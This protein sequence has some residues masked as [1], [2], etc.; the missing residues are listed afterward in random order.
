MKVNT[1]NL[2]KN[3][4]N[5]VLQLKYRN[6]DSEEGEFVALVYQAMNNCNLDMA[7]TLMKTFSDKDDYGVQEAVVNVL[8][9]IEIEIYYRALLEELPRLVDEAAEWA[10]SLIAG[11]IDA[12]PD[13]L[14]AMAKKL[15]NDIRVCLI[16]L[17]KDTGM[18]EYVSN[19]KDFLVE[20]G[21]QKNDP[22]NEAIAI[23]H[24][25]PKPVLIDVKALREKVDMTEIGFASALGIDLKT[26]RYWERGRLQPRGPALALLKVIAKKPDFV[27]SILSQS[28]IIDN[29]GMSV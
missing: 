13:L 26:L 1:T 18:I 21:H 16:H 25:K 15:S 6:N 28:K 7:K 29:S 19:A 22:N 17:I 20:V 3:W 23:I 2:D 5:R 12:N 8:N 10:E 24:N 27:M 14:A 4:S 11:E 9:S